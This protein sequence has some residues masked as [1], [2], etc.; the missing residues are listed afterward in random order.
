LSKAFK[1]RRTV[2]YVPA[3]NP[4]ALEKARGLDADCIILDLEDAVAPKAKPAARDAA[5]RAI[6]G[7][8]SRE[9]IVRIN[10]LSSAW[11]CDDLAAVRRARPN[12][13]A[14]PKV[15]DAEDVIS[16]RGQADG[17]PLWAMIESPGAVL[18]AG[19]IARAGVTALVLGTNDLLKDMG[20][21]HMPDRAN[22][23]PAMSLCVMAARAAGIVVLDGVHNDLG[24]TEGFV[25]ACRQACDFGFDGKTIIHPNQ[26]APCNDAFTPT[27]EEIAAAQRVVN[28]FAANPQAGVLTL[29]GRMVERL[30]VKIAERLLARSP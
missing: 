12:A 10:S 3:D 25:R 14:L 4:R 8:G 11:G 1:P 7:L 27:P 6:A 9:V 23:W 22:L 2:L 29:D 16:V 13:I 15:K 20:A 26:I 28:A 24:D 19:E 30:D 5:C 21:R 18:N 17:V